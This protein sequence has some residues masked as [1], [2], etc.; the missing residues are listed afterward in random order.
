MEL[1][2]EFPMYCPNRNC[3]WPTEVWMS[4]VRTSTDVSL[5]VWTGACPGCGLEL[6]L[7]GKAQPG[8]DH[9]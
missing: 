6:V 4:S 2:L 9:S 1:A 5:A 8:A 7:T 3:A